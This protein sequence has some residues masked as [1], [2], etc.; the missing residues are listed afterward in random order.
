MYRVY[1]TWGSCCASPLSGMEYRAVKDLWKVSA[2]LVVLYAMRGP[3]S[4]EC[5]VRGKLLYGS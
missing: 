5:M 3:G 2:A 4:V 1:V